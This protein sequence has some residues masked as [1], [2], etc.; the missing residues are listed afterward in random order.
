MTD[1]SGATVQADLRDANLTSDAFNAGLRLTASAHAGE[2]FLHLPRTGDAAL[3][4]ALAAN[5][6]RVNV[7]AAGDIS[8]RSGRARFQLTAPLLVTGARGAR[9]L[10]PELALTQGQNAGTAQLRA[11]LSGGGLPVMELS[12]RNL[13]VSPDGVS[14][15]LALNAHFNY[16][17][18]R[19]ARIRADDALVSWRDGQL[20]VQAQSCAARH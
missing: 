10:V 20:R 3:D 8:R 17:M 7:T 1:K 6:S 2:D 16:A 14:G 4:R 18:L 11:S 13:S 15:N 19:D 12:S 9:L 5:L